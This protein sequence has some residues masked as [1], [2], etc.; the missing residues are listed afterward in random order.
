MTNKEELVDFVAP[1]GVAI[2]TGQG[3]APHAPGSILRVTKSHAAVLE[4][5]NA[6]P[7]AKPTAP[8]SPAAPIEPKPAKQA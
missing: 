6:K 1:E 7:A 3:I 8:A 4:K 2:Y 5:F